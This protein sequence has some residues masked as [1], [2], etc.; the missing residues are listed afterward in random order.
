MMRERY[1]C[2]GAPEYAPANTMNSD[3]KLLSPGRPRDAKNEIM[4]MS[5]Y[6]GMSRDRPR[7]FGMSLVP[8]LCLIVPASMKRAA[9]MMPWLNSWKMAPWM[10][11]GLRLDAPKSTNPMW[12][13]EEKAM[14]FFK[15][16]WE[17]Q[18]RDA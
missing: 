13:I 9:V 2:N 18:T 6:F 4:R 17:R 12:P 5:E 1:G 7:N 8:A 14:S 11:M 15:S 3:T 16:I 10:P